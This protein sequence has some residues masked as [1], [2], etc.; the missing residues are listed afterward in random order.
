MVAIKKEK[1]WSPHSHSIFL[2]HEIL[3]SL[4]ILY[5]CNTFICQIDKY[6]CWSIKGKRVKNLSVS[7]SWETSLIRSELKY[8]YVKTSILKITSRLT[9]KFI[10]KLPNAKLMVRLKLWNCRRGKENWTNNQEIFHVL[11]F[12]YLVVATSEFLPFSD[13]VPKLRGEDEAKWEVD[14]VKN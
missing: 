4:M 3:V 12:L 13:L 11:L 2:V 10:T 5:V 7:L 8:S 1:I 6:A 9:L 14:C